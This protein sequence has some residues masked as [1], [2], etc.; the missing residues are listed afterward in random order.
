VLPEKH[1][2]DT[3]NLG[4]ILYF[5][6]GQKS[7]ST[8]VE[9]ANFSTIFLFL[10]E[11]FFHFLFLIALLSGRNNIKLFYHYRVGLFCFCFNFFFFS[12]LN[13]MWQFNI[14]ITDF[15]FTTLMA[16]NI[17]RRCKGKEV[18][19][20]LRRSTSTWQYVH[21]YAIHLQCIL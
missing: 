16:V 12:F 9:M 3:G 4:I 17:L 1:A 10:F 7:K 5:Q 20:G 21:V 13:Y 11:S 14:L 8:S 6:E 19:S 2:L 15:Y 18:Q